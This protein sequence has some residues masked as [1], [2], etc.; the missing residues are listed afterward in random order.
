[1]KKIL[2]FT[3]LVLLL[4]GCTGGAAPAPSTTKATVPSKTPME[5]LNH[6]VQS[7]LQASSFE[8]EF[9]LGDEKENFDINFSMKVA[10][11]TRGGYTAYW[12]KPC[13]CAEYVSG[14][15]Y[16][17]YD[18]EAGEGIADTAA[19]YLDMSYLLRLLPTL[20][21]G[22]LERFCNTA[23]MATPTANGGMRFEVNDLTEAEM[24]QLLGEEM[25]V[26]PDFVGFFALEIDAGGNLT[27]AVFPRG[28]MINRIRLTKINQKLDIPKPDWA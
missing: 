25:E 15:T 4:T 24:E 27:E 14:K 26:D 19:D 5:M 6:C 1:M 3:L 13:G 2:C 23:L 28:G 9:A 22:V 11:D 8:L 18:C 20:D 12:E 10:K 7:V 16:V 21:E 17:S